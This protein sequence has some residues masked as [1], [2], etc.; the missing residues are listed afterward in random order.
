MAVNKYINNTRGFQNKVE[1]FRIS[2]VWVNL[3]RTG[4]GGP[5]LNKRLTL[6]LRSKSS[7]IIRRDASLDKGREHNEEII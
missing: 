3:N 6:V 5:A 2:V 7:Y 1:S 4:S